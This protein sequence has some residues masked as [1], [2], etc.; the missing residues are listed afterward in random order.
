MTDLV[1]LRDGIF[2]EIRKRTRPGWRGFSPAK[3]DEH[4]GWKRKTPQ[5]V[6]KLADRKLPT[7]YFLGAQMTH[8]GRYRD[9]S[10]WWEQTAGRSQH[11]GDAVTDE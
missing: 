7:D 5:T 3:P 1:H 6:I 4:Q 8:T 2:D 9:I 10:G 11:G